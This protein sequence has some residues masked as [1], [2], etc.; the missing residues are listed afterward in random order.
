MNKQ[1]ETLVLGIPGRLVVCE[2]QGPSGFWSKS[3]NMTAG[4]ARTTTHLQYLKC[5]VQKRRIRGSQSLI[6]HNTPTM[7]ANGAYHGSSAP[8]VSSK[9]MTY[10]SL[11]SQ[12]R[13]GR[14]RQELFAGADP[15]RS[16]YQQQQQVPQEELNNEQLMR[17]AVAEHKDTTATAH[18]ARQVVGLSLLCCGMHIDQLVL[19][20]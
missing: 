20:V 3:S 7:H 17:Q 12:N 13:E 14:E 10:G 2:V 1:P 4:V 19:T 8:A 9:R 16:P 11:S 6:Q 5:N 15:Y 18:R